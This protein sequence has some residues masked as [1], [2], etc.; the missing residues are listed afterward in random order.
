MISSVMGDAALMTLR[1]IFL[2]PG[3]PTK[4][5]LRGKLVRDVLTKNATGDG[6]NDMIL[7]RERMTPTNEN[8]VMIKG[9]AHP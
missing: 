6:T 4:K 2:L 1:G 8:L 7:P 3:K 5:E 9:K